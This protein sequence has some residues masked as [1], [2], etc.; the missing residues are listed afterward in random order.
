MTSDLKLDAQTS[1]RRPFT[2]NP[3]TVTARLTEAGEPVLGITDVAVEVIRPL[4]GIGNWFAA[5]PVTMAELAKIPAEISG[6]VLT[7]PVRKYRYL[8][9]IHKLPPPANGAPTQ[10]RLFDD[11]SHGDA[12]ADDG[13]YTA[14][15]QDTVREGVYAFHVRARGETDAGTFAREARLDQFVAINLAQA[16]VHVEMVRVASPHDQ[17]PRFRAT[18][19]V[20]DRFGNHVHPSRTVNPVIELAWARPVGPVADNLDGSYSQELALP[21]GVAGP[22]KL[23][24]DLGAGTDAVKQFTWTPSRSGLTRNRILLLLAAVVVLATAGWLRRRN[25]W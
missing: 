14:R 22:L 6:E 19:R 4:D 15:Y 12:V 16:N 3:I 25:A 9:E 18:A 17:F 24:V 23:T 20:T 5:N 10:L 21:K 11:G 7:L 2:G 8:A 1:P 13:V